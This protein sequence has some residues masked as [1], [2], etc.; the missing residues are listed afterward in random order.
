MSILKQILDEVRT[1][2][3]INIFVTPLLGLERKKLRENGFVNAYIQDEGGVQYDRG[4]YLLFKPKNP[5][6][7]EEFLGEE[8]AR[9]AKIIEEYDV[10]EGFVMVVYQYDKEWEKD[11]ELIKEGKFSKTSSEFQSALPK[12]TKLHKMGGVVEVLTVQHSIFKKVQD[13]ADYWDDLYGLKL[14]YKEDEFWHHYKDR[15]IFN[16]E[17]I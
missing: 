11:I 12:T 5:D 7:F 14:D 10:K 6:K 17:K 16:I 15:E 1:W 9:K 8:R 13:Y 4:I 2:T 3:S